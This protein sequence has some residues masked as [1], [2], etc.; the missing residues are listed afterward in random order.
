MAKGTHMTV[1]TGRL[2]ADVREFDGGCSFS[3]PVTEKWDTGEHTEWYNVTCFKGAEAHVKHLE[4]GSLVQVRG[5]QR[6]R[7]A[8]DGTRFVNLVADRVDY[9]SDIKAKEE[10][11]VAVGVDSGA[12]F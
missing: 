10:G 2:S 7:V 1:V 8:E 5:R 11:S 3:V 12:P 4:K 6:T 9:L